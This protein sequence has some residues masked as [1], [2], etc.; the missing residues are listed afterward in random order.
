MTIPSMTERYRRWFEYEKD[1][2]AKVVRSLETVS[3]ERRSAA[4]YRKAVELL[5]H[6]V[7]ARRLWLYRFGVVPNP[8][9]AMFPQG[10]SLADVTAS[11][12]DMEEQWSAYLGR[13]DDAE[14]ARS[15][16]YQSL[17]AGRFRNRIEDIL[18]QLFGHSWYHPGQIATLVRAA[19][20][21]PAATDFVYWCREAI[22]TTEE[23]K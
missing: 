8:P 4:E 14:V 5:A 20:G 17:D 7:A 15:F 12:R 6:V 2:H 18:T 23:K 21:E 1:A 10:V 22:P 3:P 13:L 16:E 9:P 11:Q 19:G